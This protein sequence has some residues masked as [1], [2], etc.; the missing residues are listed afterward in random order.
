M[1][2]GA[3]LDQRI[4]TGFNRNHRGNGEG[5]IIPEE[6]AVEYVVD[7]VDTTGTVWLG[8]TLGC[9]RCHDHKFD[10]V[11][12]KEFYQLFAFFN[13]VPENGRAVKDGNSPPFIQAPTREQAG[14]LAT[15]EAE[16]AAA[17]AARRRVA[18]RGLPRRWRTGKSS[19]PVVEDGDYSVARD[20][21]VHL[22]CEP[23]A[24][25]QRQAEQVCRRPAKLS[26]PG[27][28]G[29]GVCAR[30]PPVR[31]LRRRGRLRLLRQ[32]HDVG[33]DQTRRRLRR[34]VVV[35]D[36][37]RAGRQRLE[38]AT[39]RRQVASQS[40]AALAGRCAARGDRRGRCR[41]TSGLTWP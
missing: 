28:I 39:R 5:G 1:L 21:A 27:R 7:R 24:R 12:Q 9:A 30:R 10:P 26:L 31:R 6:Y 15:L 41:R 11:S 4:A 8:L 34:R 17:E 19:H 14:R 2:P 35:A 13:H 18:S 36:D 37:R 23:A 32:V 25:R 33:L 3:T 22:P 40:C 29:A 20:L 38:R 16:L